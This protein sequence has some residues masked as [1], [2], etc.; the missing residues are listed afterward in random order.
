MPDADRLQELV[1]EVAAAYFTSSHV[2][3][4]D[5][6]MVMQQIASSLAAVKS[7]AGDENIQAEA[8]RSPAPKRMHGAQVKKSITPD[9]LISFED[10]RPYKTLRRHLA[11]RGLTPAQYREKWGLPADYP[12]VSPNYSAARSALA[13]GLGFGQQGQRGETA[14]PPSADAPAEASPRGRRKS[15]PSPG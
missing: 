4:A 15:T 11:T 9:A 10:G 5:I 13:K 6:P 14:P 1:A 2:S 3:P 12:M 8:D 7:A